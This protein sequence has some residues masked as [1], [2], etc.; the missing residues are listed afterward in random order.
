MPFVSLKQIRLS[1]FSA[2]HGCLT[3][4]RTDGSMVVRLEFAHTDYVEHVTIPAN[5]HSLKIELGY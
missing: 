4:G 5:L 3:M 1:G 2:L